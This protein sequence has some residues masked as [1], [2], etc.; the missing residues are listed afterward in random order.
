MTTPDSPFGAER[1][2]VGGLIGQ[3]LGEAG[4]AGGLTRAAAPP[5]LT[6]PPTQRVP[7]VSAPGQSA[8]VPA[9]V[10]EGHDWSV[11]GG[12]VTR[13]GGTAR[14]RRDGVEALDYNNP[15]GQ[16]VERVWFDGQIVY[17]IE[18]GELD[19]DETK[20]KVAQEYQIVYDVELDAQGK[21]ARDPDR[22]PGQ[23]N[24][25]DSVP[26]MAKYSPIWQFNYVIVPREYV[27]NTLRSESDCLSSGYPI[28]RS[29]VFEN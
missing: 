1:L 23:Y 21:L 2:T 25:Y 28:K 5:T 18:A 17:A 15:F 6:Q 11:A 22:V 14:F 13:G 27:A 24:I 26:G 3:P 16:N 4:T 29:R 19:L 12:N 9:G 8:A 7:S 20:E 10:Q